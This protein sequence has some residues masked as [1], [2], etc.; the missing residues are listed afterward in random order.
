M[1]YIRGSVEP[2]RYVM[3]GNHRDAWGFGS[4]DP[5]S[6]TAQMMEVSRVLGAKVLNGWRPRRTI[7]FLSWGAEEFA[8]TG[9][10]EFVEDYKTK[11]VIVELQNVNYGLSIFLFRLKGELS[12]SMSMFVLEDPSW[13]LQLHLQ[14]LTS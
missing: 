7:I 9:S 2:D 8:L 4:I 5:S 14:L 3:I 6:G 11:L 12:I 10:R 1:G 13:K